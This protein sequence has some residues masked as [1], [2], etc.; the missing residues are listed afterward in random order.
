MSTLTALYSQPKSE[1]SSKQ[2]EASPV[3][4]QG[5]YFNFWVTAW[6]LNLYE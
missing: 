2:R 6:R 5:L 4:L 3:D 1:L